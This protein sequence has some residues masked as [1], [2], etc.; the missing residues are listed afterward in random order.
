ME[1]CKCGSDVY[2]ALGPEDSLAGVIVESPTQTKRGKVTLFDPSALEW[3]IL[4]NEMRLA[5]LPY[6]RTRMTSF[7]HHLAPDNTTEECYAWNF[8]Q[9]LKDVSHC[10]FILLM[11]SGV[12]NEFLDNNAY[13]ISG[14]W[15]SSKF[16]PNKCVM[17]CPSPTSL[18]N[19]TIGEFRLALRKFVSGIQEAKREPLI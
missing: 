18:V 7:W 8:V 2:W 9:T 10:Q 17:A 3:R 6:D 16:L 15:K 19:G 12:T 13:A 1:K 4:R 5:G 14:L 11:G